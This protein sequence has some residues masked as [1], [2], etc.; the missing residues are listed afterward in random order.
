[1]IGADKASKLRARGFCFLCCDPEE[2]SM[3]KPAQNVPTEQCQTHAKLEEGQPAATSLHSDLEG[4][5]N[6]QRP[7]LGYRSLPSEGQS[8]YLSSLS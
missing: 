5:R 3:P 1:M 6:A 2:R 7:D 8:S 4:S